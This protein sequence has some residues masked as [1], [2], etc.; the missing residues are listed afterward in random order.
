MLK[1]HFCPPFKH[2]LTERLTSLGIMGEPRVPPLNPSET[3]VSRTANVGTVG[4]NELTPLFHPNEAYIWM[5]AQQ[6]AV[7]ASAATVKREWNCV[8]LRLALNSWWTAHGQSNG[9]GLSKGKPLAF[10]RSI[11]ALCTCI[12]YH[13]CVCTHTHTRYAQLLNVYLYSN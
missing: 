6:D 4:L 13:N 3:S 7:H 8:L 11:Y 5:V 9:V 1:T 10:R 12:S 2:L